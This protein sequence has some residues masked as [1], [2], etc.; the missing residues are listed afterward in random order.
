MPGKKLLK[1]LLPI[2]GLL[3]LATALAT[4]WLVYKATRPPAKPSH[5]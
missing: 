2:V 5:Y 3:L 4:L 1:M